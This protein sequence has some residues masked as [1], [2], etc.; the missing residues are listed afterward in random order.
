VGSSFL[1]VGTDGA[2]FKAFAGFLAAL[3]A[4]V[5]CCTE[6]LAD[7]DLRLPR[8]IVTS[9]GPYQ[10]C[11]PVVQKF[12]DSIE[13]PPEYLQHP[14]AMVCTNGS[15]AAPG[16]AWV[17]VVLLPDKIDQEIRQMQEPIG[18]LLVNENSFLSTAQIYLDLTGQLKP[19]RNNICIEAAGKPGAVYSWE[20]RSIGSPRLIMPECI[21]T[22]SGARLDI[23]GCGFSLRPDENTVQ[24]GPVK[25]PVTGADSQQLHVSIPEKFP[26]GTYNLAVSIRSYRS[27]VIR[28]QVQAPRQGQ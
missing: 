3:A 9:G 8:V 26:A 12:Y 20:I 27:N 2:T 18:R 6:A 11:S 19:G 17:R 5:L 23:N 13:I 7:A 28:V 15:E 1:A 24:L 14:L 4:S 10:S 22:I 16:F 21:N 25:L